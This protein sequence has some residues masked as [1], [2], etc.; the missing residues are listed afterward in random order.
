MKFS[1]LILQIILFSFISNQDNNKPELKGIFRIDSLLN[2][3]CLTDENYSLQFFDKKLKNGQLYRLVKTNNNYYIIESKKGHIKLA[4]NQNG[5]IL[6]AYNPNDKTFKDKMEW[7]I[8]KI[9]EN[10]YVV[11]NTGNKKF[12]EINNNFFQCINELPTPIQ[13][14]KSE[15]SKNFRF[16]FFKLCEE[17]QITPEQ[18][19]MIEN[20]PI[21]ILIKY[22]DLTDKTLNREG[23]KQI[24]KDEDNEEL[25]YS[26]RSILQYLP[27]VRKIYILMPNE[28]VKYFKPYDEIK[29]KIVYVKD[30]DLLGYE[31]ANIYTFTFNLF[32]MDK[33]GLS[34]N[35]IYMDDDFF[36]GKELKKS[37]FFYYDENEKRVVP[38]LLNV[39]FHELDKEKTLA[40]YNSLFPNKDT[41][42]PQCFMA[43]A[44]SLLSTEKFFI[45][46]YSNLE[47]INPTP[48]HN[49]I[50]YNIQDLKEIYD[51]VINNYQYAKEFLNSLQRHILTLQTQHF[52][53]LYQLNIKHRK[54]HSISFNVI[55]MKLL[56]PYYLNIDLFAINTGG[57]EVYTQEDFKKQR[58][59][60]Q[61]RFPNPTKYEIYDNTQNSNNIQKIEKEKIDGNNNINDNQNEEGKNNI[62]VLNPA[63]SHFIEIENK[64]LTK[65]NE[66]QK[67][68]IIISN[69]LII[70]MSLLIIILFYLYCSEKNRNKN[71]Y[72]RLY[73][74]DNRRKIDFSD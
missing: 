47:F 45:D 18:E 54:V 58:E 22:I 1:F 15:I 24:Q 10:Q 26:V 68:I 20:E 16:N 65:I 53:D 30:K 40:Q 56:Q 14:H 61:E 32:K 55:P 17:V 51:L 8:I 66:K 29:E 70:L 62:N 73:D 34:N 13:E 35:F 50:S 5:H 60:M 41:I 4:A 9:E 21:D 31:S 36:I 49:A 63:D 69:C 37:N 64:A 74:N 43:W 6:M 57:D 28:K 33:F 23:I 11:Q 59:I 46:H 48:T 71:R 72:T 44:F 25:K 27:W 39:D 38:S 3:F 19:K 2:D 42:S 7:D 12:M 52:V 67:F